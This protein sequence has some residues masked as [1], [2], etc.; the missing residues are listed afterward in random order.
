MI[1]PNEEPRPDEKKLRFGSFAIHAARGLVRDQK[2]RRKTMFVIVLVA[3]V[4]LF[5]GATFLA[6]VLNP[7]LRP[8]WFIVYWAICAW[9]TVTAV[10]LAVFDLLQVRSQARHEK[11]R[12]DRAIAEQ[13]E[14]V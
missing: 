2:A 10:L 4:L 3:L 6:P 8:G 12:L 9:M 1:S 11:R 14:E 13:I 5:C 7:H